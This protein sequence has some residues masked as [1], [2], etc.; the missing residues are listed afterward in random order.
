MNRNKITGDN[1]ENMAIDYLKNKGYEIRFSNWRTGHL[2][3]DIIAEKDGILCFIEVKTRHSDDGIYE[4]DVLSDQKKERLIE[5]AEIF[6]DE[7]NIKN[8]IRFD[9]IF[10]ILQNRI[11]KIRHIEDA[12]T[13]DIL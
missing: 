2:E 5:A 6:I 7:K 9:L 11:Q 3:V 1:G 4:E 13:H 8:E 12:F 10:I